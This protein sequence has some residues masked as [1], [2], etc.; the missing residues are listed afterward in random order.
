MSFQQDALDYLNEFRRKPASFISTL[1]KVKLN[2]GQMSK[3]SKTVE[4]IK[5]IE[6]F[7][8]I[9]SKSS[10]LPTFTLSKDLSAAAQKQLDNY[11][12]SSVEH[13]IKQSE[14]VNLLKQFCEGFETVYMLVNDI[15]EA[16]EVLTR[17][18]F[19]N[20]DKE[21]KNRK[22]LLDK[23]INFVGIA[24]KVID[25]DNYVMLIL[26]DNATEIKPKKS[27]EGLDE[28][29]QAFDFFDVNECGR[30]NI[31]ETVTALTSL[32]YQ[33]RN[34][35]LFSIVSELDTPENDKKGVDWDTFSGH[36]MARISNVNTREGLRRIFDIFI[37]DPV[38]DTVTLTTLKR[39][40]RE[41]GEPIRNE[42]LQ[43]MI[44]RAASNG[45]ELTFDEFYSYMT[46]SD[47]K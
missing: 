45:V 38:Q 32:G 15:D 14:L 43:D 42:E 25:G 21:K 47:R 17:M 30:L 34:P 8:P 5:D 18:I 40:C 4:F 19:S 26:A 36:V 35:A 13:N 27:Y 3:N 20:N 28:L 1:E 23:A 7:I 10:G 29:K 12:N 22:A 31:K 33:N 37:D 11:A 16:D 41:L 46:S 9:I 6:S 39:I 24:D 2:L 44:Q